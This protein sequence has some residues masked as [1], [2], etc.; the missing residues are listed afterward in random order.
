MNVRCPEIGVN[1][2]RMNAA[3]NSHATTT[4]TAVSKTWRQTDRRTQ[5]NY[6][7]LSSSRQHRTSS[8][9]IN[10]AQHL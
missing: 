4:I 2:L 3:G 10:T 8:A 1:G 5:S 7:H 6:Q 9:W